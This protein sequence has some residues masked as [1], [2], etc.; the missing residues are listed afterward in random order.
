[1]HIGPEA[2]LAITIGVLLLA[3]GIAVGIAPLWT[4][5]LLLLGAGG[6]LVFLDAKGRPIGGR[7]HYF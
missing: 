4:I 7:R 5:G 1:V 6:Y 3:V 2:G